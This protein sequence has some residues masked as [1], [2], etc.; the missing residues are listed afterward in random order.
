MGR[1]RRGRAVRS[2]IT[3]EK[4]LKILDSTY[5]GIAA[6][7][8]DGRIILFNKA[9]KRFF[10]L[11]DRSYEG[12]HIV[13]VT[14]K[15]RMP[16]VI[17]SGTAEINH[18]IKIDD[19]LTL[20]TSRM[21]IWDEE[22]KVEGAVAVFKELPQLLEL[23]SEV[24]RLEEMQSMMEAIFSAAQDAISVTNQNGVVVMMNQAYANLLGS[25]LSDCIGQPCELDCEG[26]SVH[27][28][29]LESGCE[30]RGFHMFVGKKRKEI[31]A[32]G[33]PIIVDGKLSGSVAVA[34]DLTE[35]LSL[36]REL[37][38]AKQVI[39]EI[40]GKYIFDDI[41]GCSRELTQ[42]V[43]KAKRAAKTP[44]TVLLM[45]ESGTGKEIFAHA[46]HNGSDRA[47]MP[48]IRVNCAAISEALLESELFGYVEGAFTGAKK[49]GRAGYFEQADHG[50][51]FLDEIGKMSL[52]LQAKMLR[53]LQEKELIRV[54]A[55]EP[56]SVDVRV[57][58]ATNIDL[59]EE[60]RQG[61][62]REDLYYRLNMV[63][64]EIPPLRSRK[65]DMRIL[66][67]HMIKKYN[68]EYGRQIRGITEEAV[69]VLK[70]YSWK[71]NVRELG[72]Y[73]GRTIIDMD[74]DDLVIEARHLPAKG[75]RHGAGDTEV[76]AMSVEHGS[77]LNEAV[78]E[79]ER[80]YVR[81]ALLRNGGNK[82][83]T[84]RELNISVRSV[85]NKIE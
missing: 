35:L 76:C 81:E 53:V 82:T 55:S 1:G 78:K 41:L 22:G 47:L 79:F 48:F 85:Y 52:T 61:R 37:D 60:I 46:I 5:D 57:I 75:T 72:N 7:D 13:D 45:G 24:D 63:P 77:T 4:L 67:E 27:R 83:K 73:I 6:V 25:E 12:E 40:E 74:Q 10:R 11:Q 69:E 19:E 62:F 68:D 21:P 44:A 65:E 23:S 17:T 16:Q 49:T 3:L 38:K 14:P 30:K 59:E 54:G 33:A 80:K 9:A 36:T 29:V 42:A 39:R 8:Q 18:S 51:I 26:A 66:A 70:S 28:A 2:R 50:T 20:V 71:G 84:A 34:H 64:V 58:A 56:I 15:A 32:H 43:E 31:I